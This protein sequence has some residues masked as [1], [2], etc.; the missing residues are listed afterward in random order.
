VKDSCEYTRISSC[1]QS[2]RGCSAAWGLGEGHIIL[3]HDMCDIKINL[4]MLVIISS[5]IVVM[6]F[7]Q[8][9]VCVCACVHARTCKLCILSHMWSDYRWGLDW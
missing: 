4:E 3:H 8:N 6:V 2:T 7:F 1:G 5:K 9:T